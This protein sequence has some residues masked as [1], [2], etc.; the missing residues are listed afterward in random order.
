M[1]GKRQVLK[2]DFRVRPATKRSA[3][4]NESP[5]KDKETIKRELIAKMEE[6]IDDFIDGM[7]NGFEYVIDMDSE[8]ADRIFKIKPLNNENGVF[9]SLSRRE[10]EIVQMAQTG[11]T[12]GEISSILGILPS[13]VR[14]HFKSIYRK[15]GIRERRDLVEC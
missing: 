1:A 10:R 15:T 9:D 11:F 5:K 3:A 6:Q 4:A 12:D 14:Q 7:K 2:S 13:T 8:E